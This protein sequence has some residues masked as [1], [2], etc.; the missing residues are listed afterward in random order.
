MILYEPAQLPLIV[1]SDITTLGLG[2]QA[3]VAV[4][5]APVGTV[6]LQFNVTF[7]RTPT[8]TGPSVSP[9]LT[10]CEAV[11]ELP[12]ASVAVQVLTNLYEPTH[13]PF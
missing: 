2:S 13:V 7:V 3:S 4:I 8:K 10:V 6:S 11:A 9:T 1:L 12:Q 5:D